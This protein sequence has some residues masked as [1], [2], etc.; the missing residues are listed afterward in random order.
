[1]AAVPTVSENPV[2]QRHY[3]VQL[4]VSK[5]LG[6]AIARIP[7]AASSQDY[8]RIVAALV[9]QYQGGVIALAADYYGDMRAQ[10]SVASPYRVPTIS[11]APEDAIQ[12]YIDEATKE[13]DGLSE[14][15]ERQVTEFAQNLAIS[16][17]T[18]EL[19][20]A[21][22]EDPER[23]RWARV[24]R[25]AACSFC[26]MLA[27]RGAVYRTEDSGSF[28]PHRGC[29]C[30]VE[31]A[32]STSTYEPPAHIRAAQSLWSESTTDVDGTKAKQNAFRRALAA[33]RRG[34]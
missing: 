16:A 9:N 15:Y 29:R 3:A 32:W 26:L 10:A 11:P 4:G 22:D 1:M 17:G 23:V 34:A 13:L 25:S 18:D 20:T 27:S 5:S 7:L 12:A 21:I 31:M 14:V 8:L 33:E 24:T 6:D 2:V 28:R 30:D 19:F